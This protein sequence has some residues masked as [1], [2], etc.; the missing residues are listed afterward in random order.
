MGKL[1]IIACETFPS[2]GQKNHRVVH[3]FSS[4]VPRRIKG[5]CGPFH[6]VNSL[7]FAKDKQ[8]LLA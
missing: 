8:Q 7:F 3:H 4:K 2:V 1:C 6:V 5:H